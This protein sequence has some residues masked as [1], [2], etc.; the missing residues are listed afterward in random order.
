M[1]KLFDYHHIIVGKNFQILGAEWIFDFSFHALPTLRFT[2]K[3]CGKSISYSC[4]TFY[5]PKKLIEYKE[6][7]IFS[8]NRLNSLLQFNFSADV[9]IHE[10][11]VVKIFILLFVF[12][13]L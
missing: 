12:I 11:G 3:Y 1:R 10:C 5:V 9:I 4:D 7:G 2:A 6:K 13:C 8:E